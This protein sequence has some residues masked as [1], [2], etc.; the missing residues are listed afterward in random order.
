MPT[1]KKVVKAKMQMLA[2]RKHPNHGFTL[3]EL[4]IVISLLSLLSALGARAY[5]AKNSTPYFEAIIN[6]LEQAKLKAINEGRR[7]DLSCNEITSLAK[8][9]LSHQFYVSCAS[10][11]P[12]PQENT[13]ISFFADGSSSG[14]LITL[15]NSGQSNT[16]QIDWLTGKLDQS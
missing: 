11:L 13:T 2:S 10:I 5:R 9:G 15:K 12:S 8:T 3:L 4:L 6:T 14:G 16:I 7:I 1:T